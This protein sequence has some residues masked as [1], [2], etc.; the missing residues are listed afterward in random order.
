MEDAAKKLRAKIQEVLEALRGVPDGMSVIEAMAFRQTVMQIAMLTVHCWAF[1]KGRRT[2]TSEEITMY[3]SKL[4][5]KI[6]EVE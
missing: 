1:S 3:N 2:K 5:V 6:E 4:S